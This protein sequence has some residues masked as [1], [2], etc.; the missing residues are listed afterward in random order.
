MRCP[1]AMVSGSGMSRGRVTFGGTIA[2]RQ[3]QSE[4]D[5]QATIPRV[6]ASAVGGCAMIEAQIR[7]QAPDSACTTEP[8]MSCL[9]QVRVTTVI[10]DTDGYTTMS[11]EIIGTSSGKHWAYCV[12]GSSL[13]YQDVST[14]GTREPGV[15]D[16]TMR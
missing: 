13:A 6:C 1:G 2:H 10:D 8:D 16:L 3:A 11:N 12:T 7:T 5:V 14:T 9:C 4:V 15:V